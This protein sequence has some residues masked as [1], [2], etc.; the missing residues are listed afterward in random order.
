MDVCVDTKNKIDNIGLACEP[1][2]FYG[3]EID[4]AEELE[5]AN[6]TSFFRVYCRFLEKITDDMYLELTLED[7]ISIIE[8]IFQDSLP[9]FNYPR[10]HINHYDPDK[11]TTDAVDEKG[12]AVVTGAWYDTLTNEEE[13]IIAEIMLTNWYKRQLSSTRVTSMRY[14]TSDFKQTSQAAHMQR[15]NALIQEQRKQVNHKQKLY[16]RRK[17]DKD[18]MMVPNTDNFAGVGTRRTKAILT[19]FGVVR[20]GGK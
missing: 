7:T 3:G 17:L 18:G 10:F 1:V 19:Q 5:I 16:T 8:S 11:V 14:S 9:E 2:L 12:N 6:G 15:L 4:M 13:D 20:Y